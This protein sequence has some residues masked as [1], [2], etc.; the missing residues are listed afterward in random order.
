VV[1]DPATGTSFSV[2]VVYGFNTEAQ[3]GELWQ[4]LT[5]V[6]TNSPLSSSAWLLLGDFN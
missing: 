4:D 2:A 1:F 6:N 3:R 5:T